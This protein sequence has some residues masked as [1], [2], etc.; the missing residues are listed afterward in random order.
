MQAEYHRSSLVGN[1]T[2]SAPNF[3]KSLENVAIVHGSCPPLHILHHFLL[4]SVF[5]FCTTSSL[6]HM[7]W[8]FHNHMKQHLEFKPI[9]YEY[10]L[11][12][13]S[14]DHT[15]MTAPLPVCS[16]KLSIVGPGQYYGGGPRWNPGCCRSTFRFCSLFSFHLILTDCLSSAARHA[17]FEV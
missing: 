3:A 4:L 5:C 8:Y 17:F 14:D 9:I 10:S 11:P 13:G 7:A 16:A 15:T 12:S 6:D 2:T 1:S